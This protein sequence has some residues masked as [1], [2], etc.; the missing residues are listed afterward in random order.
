MKWCVRSDP[1]PTPTPS[2]WSTHGILYK[3]LRF[4]SV[5]VHRMR[6][7]P[8]RIYAA[9]CLHFQRGYKN[10]VNSCNYSTAIENCTEGENDVNKFMALLPVDSLNARRKMWFSH[11]HQKTVSP[12]SHS[13]MDLKALHVAWRNGMQ[14]LMFAKRIDENCIPLPPLETKN[15]FPLHRQNE[16]RTAEKKRWFINIFFR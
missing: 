13:E 14:M 7:A 2:L 8:L 5:F 15:C 11:A 3:N 10:H 16:Q 1:T 9:V 12:K 4:T 6:Q